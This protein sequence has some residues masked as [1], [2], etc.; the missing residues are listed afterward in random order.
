MTSYPNLPGME[1]SWDMKLSELFSKSESVGHPREQPHP[2][3][4]SIVLEL[5]AE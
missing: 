4:Y 5:E 3:I 1:V 2:F